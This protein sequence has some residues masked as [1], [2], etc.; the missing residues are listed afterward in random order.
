MMNI[1]FD[2][3]KYNLIIGSWAFENL[4]DREVI[5]FFNKCRLSLLGCRKTPGMI[6]FKESIHDSDNNF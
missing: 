1:P 4:T 6:I 3:R 5:E 2:D